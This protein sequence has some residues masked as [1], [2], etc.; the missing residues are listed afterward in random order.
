MHNCFLRFFHF[1]TAVFILA[2][3]LQAVYLCFI[4]VEYIF[5]RLKPSSGIPLHSD[6]L[7]SV[8]SF[9]GFSFFLGSTET[10]GCNVCMCVR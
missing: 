9:A 6:S 10:M 2:S 7:D 3:V 5:S 4:V 8:L 1:F